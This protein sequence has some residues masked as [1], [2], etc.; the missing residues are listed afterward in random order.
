[1]KRKHPRPAPLN[2]FAAYKPGYIHLFLLLFYFFLSSFLS[3]SE[4]LRLSVCLF[5][6]DRELTC[7]TVNPSWQLVYLGGRSAHRKA[8]TYTE[9]HRRVWKHAV[10]LLLP[11]ECCFL[12]ISYNRGGRAKISNMQFNQNQSSS[13]RVM[14]W[15]SVKI[16]FVQ[17]SPKSRDLWMKCT[18]R[19]QS[20]F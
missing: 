20:T 13:S 11:L 4:H 15:R 6:N 14:I 8:C 17:L 1:M 18:G 9:Q 16:S 3:V 19:K 5:D 10:A 12:T 7:E 2:Q